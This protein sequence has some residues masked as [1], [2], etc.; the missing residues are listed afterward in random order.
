MVWA[1]RSHHMRQVLDRGKHLK[2]HSNYMAHQ[3][4]LRKTLRYEQIQVFKLESERIRQMH[5]ASK[6]TQ[7]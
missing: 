2:E 1:H 3:E 5:M 6:H 4:T 7:A